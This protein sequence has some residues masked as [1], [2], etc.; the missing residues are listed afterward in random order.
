MRRK[1]NHPPDFSMRPSRLLPRPSL[2]E[3]KDPLATKERH[4]S[5]LSY[6]RKHADKLLA[7]CEANGVRIST[8]IDV[9]VWKFTKGRA[10]AVWSPSTARLAITHDTRLYRCSWGKAHEYEQVIAA[11]TPVFGTEVM[12]WL[13]T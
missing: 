10:W 8:S 13:R 9:K 5:R 7:W 6:A 3:M 12:R 1:K 4:F 2:L 11:L